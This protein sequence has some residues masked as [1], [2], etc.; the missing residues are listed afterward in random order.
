MAVEYMIIEQKCTHSNV[1]NQLNQ[2]DPV[3]RENN[4]NETAL[5]SEV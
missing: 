4:F 2:S 3:T 5:Y 1:I